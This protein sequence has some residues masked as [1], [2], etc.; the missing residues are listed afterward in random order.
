MS[1]D[2]RKLIS[3][4]KSMYDKLEQKTTLLLESEQKLHELAYYDVLSG[5][6]NR[7]NFTDYLKNLLDKL[8]KENN[9]VLSSV[10]VLLIDL[11]RF[12]QVNDTLGHFAGDFL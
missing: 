1:N 9:G 11:D 10:A 5:L 8:L 3:E 4:Y 7:F 2:L 12:K 6:P